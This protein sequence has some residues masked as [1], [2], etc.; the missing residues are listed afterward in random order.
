[1]G[2]YSLLP[3]GLVLQYSFSNE[4]TGLRVGPL[5]F[6]GRDNHYV[7]SPVRGDWK[8]EEVLS[9]LQTFVKNNKRPVKVALLAD[10]R[11]FEPNWFNFLSLQKQAG[12][13]FSGIPWFKPDFSLDTLIRLIVGCDFVITK[14]EDSEK[15]DVHVNHIYR[16]NST[17]RKLLQNGDVPF[18]KI[19]DHIVLP[20]G[21]RV[22]IYQR[23]RD[24]AN[25]SARN[26]G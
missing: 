14:S 11:Y 16:Y 4:A 8:N 23:A 5:V 19:S 24:P 17:V 6:S 18:V 1:M 20:D 10:E 13:D 2:I 26:R 25:S 9:E 21:S 15:S 7:Y 22:S 3:L 12:F